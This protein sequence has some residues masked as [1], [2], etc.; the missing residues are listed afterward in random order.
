M[1]PTAFAH[2]MSSVQWQ[3]NAVTSN[4]QLHSVH[5]LCTCCATY[6]R[7][8]KFSNVKTGGYVNIHTACNSSQFGSRTHAHGPVIRLCVLLLP[9]G[10]ITACMVTLHHLKTVTGIILYCS[11]VSN[12]MN[13]KGK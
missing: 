1:L 6:I 3:G 2:F 13:K 5:K 9:G 4:I 11:H 12:F 7:Y 8:L 10:P